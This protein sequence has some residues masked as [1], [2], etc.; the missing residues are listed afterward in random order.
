[1]CFL[2]TFTPVNVF[3]ILLIEKLHA[4]GGRFLGYTK[5]DAGELVIVPEEAEVITRIYQEYLEGKSCRKIIKGLET[6]G[7]LMGEGNKRW[8]ESSITRC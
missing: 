1:M 3:S 8:H 6:D 4:R 7:I 5:D 2:F